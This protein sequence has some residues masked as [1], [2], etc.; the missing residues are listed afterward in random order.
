MKRLINIL[1]HILI[2][3]ILIPALGININTH[4]CGQTNDVSKSLVIPGLLNPKECDKCHKEVVVV[5]S[6]C[7]NEENEQQ[8]NTEENNKEKNCCEDISEYNSYEYISIR[9][10]NITIDY[11]EVFLPFVSSNLLY[12]IQEP[13]NYQLYDEL[14]RRP[15]DVDILTF[16]CSYLI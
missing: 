4:I 6:C 5:K 2:V 7:S 10:T 8:A 12:E 15:Y 3:L 1:S 14:R 13:T 16:N 9:A 11:S